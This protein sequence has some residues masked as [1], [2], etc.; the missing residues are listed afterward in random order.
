M[1]QEHLVRMVLVD[2]EPGNLSR[3]LVPQTLQT[4]AP[5][6]SNPR[7]SFIPP[8]TIMPAAQLLQ[9]PVPKPLPPSDDPMDVDQANS[10][11]KRERRKTTAYKS[12]KYVEITDEELVKEEP[13]DDAL[14]NTLPFVH[15]ISQPGAQTHYTPKPPPPIMHGGILPPVGHPMHKELLTCD[16][17]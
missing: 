13:A 7:T 9:L 8:P 3:F 4:P 6:N 5:T 12:K 1:A 14:A 15:C 17:C 10:K 11:Q 2:G 16:T